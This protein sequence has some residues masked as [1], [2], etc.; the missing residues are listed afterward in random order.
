MFDSNIYTNYEKET[1]F[2]K[3]YTKSLSKYDDFVVKMCKRKLH[4]QKIYLNITYLFH[5][6]HRMLVL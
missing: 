4:W 2:Y 5:V 6:S 3:I 1:A